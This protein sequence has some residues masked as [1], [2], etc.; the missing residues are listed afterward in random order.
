MGG[1]SRGTHD[2]RIVQQTKL[3]TNDSV[4][5]N[6][7]AEVATNIVVVEAL[8]SSKQNCYTI[9]ST[10]IVCKNQQRRG[11]GCRH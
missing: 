1:G 4:K 5:A 11:L 6:V 3:C 8:K 9:I 10:R 7:G 2:L